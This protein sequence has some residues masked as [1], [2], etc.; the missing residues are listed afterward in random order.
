M[1]RLLNQSIH[2]TILGILQKTSDLKGDGLTLDKTES[3]LNNKVIL[4]DKSNELRGN[5]HLE[6]KKNGHLIKVEDDHNLIVTAGR[7]K[8]ARLLGGGYNGRISKIGIGE[9][10][11]ATTESDTNLTNAVL[12][13]ITSVD[14]EGTSVKFNFSIGTSVGNG[15]NVTEF[16]L[17]FADNT[18][19][20]RRI[21][22]RIID[23][24]SDIEIAGY[25]EIY[26]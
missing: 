19:F 18:M 22:Q 15:L 10:T 5:V 13:D 7:A 12:V 17:F 26:L 8:L 4:K 16:G 6:I 3:L 11:N 23:K 2:L 9:G 14:Y 25:W 1:V 24:E 20:S 21:R